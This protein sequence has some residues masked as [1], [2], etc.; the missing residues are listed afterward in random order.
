[1]E[2]N[3]LLEKP[4]NSINS[5]NY[6]YSTRK[7]SIIVIIIFIFITIMI[8]SQVLVIFYIAQISDAAKS[9]KMYQFNNTEIIEY[10]NKAETII[11]YVCDKLIKC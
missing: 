7:Y 5:T 4:I 6:I 8:I 2:S 11:T 3:Y 9:F 1:M 10:V